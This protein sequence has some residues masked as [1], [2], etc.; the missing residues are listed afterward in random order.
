MEGSLKQ[1]KILEVLP[2]DEGLA[3][4]GGVSRIY[5]LLKSGVSV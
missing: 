3:C 1:Y 4:A 2:S 5:E